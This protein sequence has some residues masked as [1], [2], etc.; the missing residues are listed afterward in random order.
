[1]MMIWITHN[2]V[3]LQV[4]K[5]LRFLFK[6]SCVAFAILNIAES[7]GQ[8]LRTQSSWLSSEDNDESSNVQ[9]AST[10]RNMA[11]KRTN[12]PKPVTTAK[13]VSSKPISTPPAKPV[14]TMPVAPTLG[15]NVLFRD[16]FT[17]SALNTS[18]WSI[19]NWVLGRTQLG[20]TP[21]VN[22][23][24]ARLTYDT[25]GF[26]G[27]EIYTNRLFSRGTY[28]LEMEGRL[29]LNRP[30]PSGLVAAFFTYV[31]NSSTAAAD[32]I[33]I[34]ILTKQV[35]TGV[36]GTKVMFTTWNDFT[37]NCNLPYKWTTN[38]F[39]SGLNMSDWHSFVIQWVPGKTSWFIDG[40]LAANTTQA[41]PEADS[42]IRFNFWAPKS[43]WTDA[44]DSSFQPATSSSS[45]V[46]Y[47]YEVDYVEVRQLTRPI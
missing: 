8:L 36:N 12:A 26:K 45:N 39:I 43:T 35:N 15:Y 30:L 24:I 27:T 19:G 3:R 1:M 16:D 17:G 37:T 32:E 40:A 46:R 20:N 11:I 25:Y 2:D 18:T 33:D 10:A 4:W 38:P 21:V 9:I 22:G 42:P 28:G 5:H 44:Y 7:K 29:R 13:P 23:G 6:F 14:A 31:Y 47:Y 41:Q 34:E